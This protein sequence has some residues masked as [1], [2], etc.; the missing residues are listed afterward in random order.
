MREVRAVPTCDD[1][2]AGAGAVGVEL[3]V[4][5]DATLEQP[6]PDDVVEVLTR[7]QSRDMPA[8]EH[9]GTPIESRGRR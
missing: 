4:E 2:P 5:L 9:Q 7:L 3:R 8:R 6:L 1:V